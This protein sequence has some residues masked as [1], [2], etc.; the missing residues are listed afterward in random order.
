VIKMRL[1][2]VYF[3]VIFCFSLL[4]SCGKAHRESN[5]EANT[6]TPVALQDDKL[7]IKSY[8]RSGD[9]IEELYQ[10]LVDKNPALQKLETDIEEFRYQPDELKEM[11]NKYDGKSSSYYS[12]ASC[13][14]AA[15]TDSILKKR[16]VTLISNSS[17]LYENKTKELNSLLKQISQNGSTITDHHTALKIVLTLP[18]IEKYQKDNLPSRKKFKTLIKTQTDLIQQTDSLIP[19]N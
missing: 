9:I 12:S 19:G 16:I 17:K 13:R 7:E 6:E 1:C 5:S 15:I 18:L 11:F 4:T 10:E 2:T 3:V 8:S 14:V